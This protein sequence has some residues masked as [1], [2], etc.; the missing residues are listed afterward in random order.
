VPLLLLSPPFL[1]IILFGSTTLLT[2]MTGISMRMQWPLTSQSHG[3]VSQIEQLVFHYRSNSTP[4]DHEMFTFGAF[5]LTQL[6]FCRYG[7]CNLCYSW[8]RN[9]EA[10]FQWMKITYITYLHTCMPGLPDFS[11]YNIPK[12]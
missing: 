4:Q 6:P 11:K 1:P 9:T 8:W 5:Q 2:G 7:N 12:R 3:S 10:F